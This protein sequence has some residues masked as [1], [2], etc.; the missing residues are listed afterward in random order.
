MPDESF[1][2]PSRPLALFKPQQ[3][4]GVHVA[5]IQVVSPRRY[6]DC[7]SVDI[8]WRIVERL[9]DRLLLVSLRR[10]QAMQGHLFSS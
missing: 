2:R 5:A 8:K 4:V 6:S 10:L 7:R 9:A 1:S 3:E